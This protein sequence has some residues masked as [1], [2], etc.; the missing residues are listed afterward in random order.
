VDKLKKLWR[1]FTSREM[2]LYLIFGV[3]T[4]VLNIVVFDRCYY[5]LSW[6]WQAANT[7]AWVLAVLFAFLTNKL[8]VFES[9]SF[10]AKIFWKEF[11]GFLAARLLSLG[12]DTFCMWL[13]LDVFHWNALLAKIAD[14][15]VVVVINYILSK[16][17]I[18]RKK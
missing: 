15:V 14:N 16:R 13:L 10:E 7:F 18:F 11:L 12:V 6:P 9:R 2:I 8:F 3:L 17:I 4:T 5:G 1:F